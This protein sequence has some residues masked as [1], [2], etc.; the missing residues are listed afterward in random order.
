MTS[1][2]LPSKKQKFFHTSL[3][4]PGLLAQTG[5]SPSNAQALAI[6]KASWPPLYYLD[7]SLSQTFQK[8]L[9]F[10]PF[11]LLFNWQHSSIGS[12][13]PPNWKWLTL[14]RTRKLVDSELVTLALFLHV[15]LH[16]Y[17]TCLPPPSPLWEVL[18]LRVALSH[19]ALRHGCSYILKTYLCLKN[20]WENVILNKLI[21]TNKKHVKTRVCMGS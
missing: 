1:P 6:L 20:P 12:T 18:H 2:Q 15:M 3:L 16:S 14:L 17:S 19:F 4:H 11:R 9:F 7:H 8:L 21:K 10:H 13:I 5:S